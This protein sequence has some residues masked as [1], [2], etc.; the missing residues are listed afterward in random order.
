MYRLADKFKIL[1]FVLY[2]EKTHTISIGDY[3]PNFGLKNT[4]ND[5]TIFKSQAGQPILL[6]FYASDRFPQCQE[7]ALNIG[8][9]APVLAEFNVKILSISTDQPA[10]RKNFAE[11]TNLPFLFLSDPEYK[12]SDVYG[13]VHRDSQTSQII[14]HRTMFLL[15]AN[16]RVTHIYHVQNI[17]TSLQE[18]LSDLQKIPKEEPH[19]ISMQAP[20][21]LIPKVFP[22]DFC[23]ELIDIWHTDNG[24]S[25]FMKAIG[26]KTGGYIDHSHKI[27]NDHFVQDEK[28]TN[29]INH[30]ILTRV[31]PEVEKAYNYRITR[32]ESYRIAGY[33][34]QAGGFFKAHRDNTTGGTAHRRW[35]MSL[36]LNSDEYEGGYLRFPEYG[37]HLYKPGTGDAVIFSCSLLHEAT[38]VTSGFR[39]VLLN[40]FYGDKEAEAR[41]AYENRAKN[42]YQQVERVNA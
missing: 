33:D 34:S 18:L 8:K 22:L 40:F 28:L 3:A 39:F 14:Y 23:Q 41:I 9:I 13:V 6:I 1:T 20:V 27:R 4:E 36:N 11:Q 16:L 5:L 29:R 2:L 35:A 10:V 37:P 7:I 15:D 31:V 17:L 30:Y 32:Q 38:R 19:V 24:E 25:G 12:V 42:N 26:N 21:L